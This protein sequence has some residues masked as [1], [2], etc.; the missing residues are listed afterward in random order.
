MS[1]N[2]ERG[3]RSERGSALWGTGSRGGDRSSVLWGKGGRG[4]LVSLRRGVRPRSPDGCAGGLGQGLERQFGRDR[5]QLHRTEPPER[6]RQGRRH[7]PVLERHIRR[8]VED[9]EVSASSRTDMKRA[10]PDRRRRGGRA[11][12]PSSR[13]WLGVPGLTVTPNANVK[14]AGDGQVE[15]A[16]AVRVR[17]RRA[18]GRRLDAVQRQ[19][20]RRSRSS[21]R[22]SRSAA[23]FGNRV[24][25]ERQPLDDRGQHLVRRPAR[26]RHVRRRH[27]GG[28]SS[29]PGRRCSW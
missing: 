20:C 26:A 9:A 12:Q 5:V 10:R 22:A 4:I 18:L 13:S 25:R 27:C 6:D 3:A 21:T 15:P 2:T 14:L 23:D 29:R 19:D 11:G 8:R 17:Q 24:D 7:H 1:Q 28:R 16:L